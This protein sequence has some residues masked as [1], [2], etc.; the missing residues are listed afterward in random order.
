MRFFT[1]NFSSNSF[2]ACVIDTSEDTKVLIISLN[3]PKTSKLLN[4]IIRG[5]G[6]IDSWEKHEVFNSVADPFWG[7]SGSGSAD[8][9][10][11]LVDPDPDSVPDPDPGS[12]SCYFRH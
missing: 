4:A 7:G 9:C 1:F 6:E 8:P 10:L 2:V 11:F 3:F 5:R 12:G